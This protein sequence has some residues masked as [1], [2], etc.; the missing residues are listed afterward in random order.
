LMRSSSKVYEIPRVE[1]AHPGYCSRGYGRRDG[2]L[3]LSMSSRLEMWGERPPCMQNIF[4][5][6][7][8]AQGI[9][10]KTFTKLQYLDSSIDVITKEEIRLADGIT[11]LGQHHPQLAELA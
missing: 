3:T 1:S 2:Q 4:S 9:Q 8:A 7:R 6:T 5:A 11:A 10:L